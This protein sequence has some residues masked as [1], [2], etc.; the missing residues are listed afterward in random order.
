VAQPSN[1][2]LDPACGDRP[3][4]TVDVVEWV[5]WGYQWQLGS[6][7]HPPFAAWLAA[8]FH[9][10]TPNS[11]IGVYVLSYLTIAFTLWCV[12]RLAQD[13]LTPR[14]ALISA[15]CLEGYLMFS[16][17]GADYSNTLVL[18][19]TW[20]ATILSL[21]QALQ[22]NA[23]RWWLLL[24]VSVGLSALTKYQAMLLIAPLIAFAIVEPRARVI[25]RSKEVYIAAGIALLIFLPHLIWMQS[26]NFITVQFA[27]D[28]AAGYQRWYDRLRFPAVFLFDQS[29]RII[30]VLAILA[31]LT[32][33]GGGKVAAGDPG[34]LRF[35]GFAFLGPIVLLLAISFLFGLRLLDVWG[36]P[37]WI[38]L[39][40]F[41]LAWG[42]AGAPD[43]SRLKRVGAVAMTVV[44]IMS[45]IF[46]VRSFWPA[47][48]RGRPLR[49]HYPGALIARNVTAAYRAAYG[50]EPAIIGGGAWV[51]DNIVCYSKP[52]PTLYASPGLDFVVDESYAL[53]TSDED[54]RKRGGVLVWEADREAAT[55][56]S[57]LKDR[58][59]TAV[60]QPILT[61]PYQRASRFAS[62]QIGWA[63]IPPASFVAR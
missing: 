52:V 8:A 13:I 6:Q 48:L 24:G 16:F 33:A 15:L 41:L 51:A 50:T 10:L 20:M 22:T 55:L 40:V 1:R 2:V 12:W 49:E 30:P 63:L 32:F 35:L 14:L 18:C 21:Q 54:L 31:P 17:E 28:R 42:K 45:T 53:W 39:G 19:A 57:W 47:A 5:A 59:P 27:L 25:W 11:L 26:T 56:P 62:A 7:K 46:G 4:G 34:Q 23:L 43:A 9:N 36:I 58:F 38:L 3:N 44:V 29:L 37:F 60:L 61:V